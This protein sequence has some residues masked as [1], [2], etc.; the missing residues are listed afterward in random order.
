MGLI[1]EHISARAQ[2]LKPYT[3]REK[4]LLA[5]K[6][7][8]AQVRAIEAGEASINPTDVVAQGR[9]RSG[10]MTLQY[11]DDFSNIEPVIDKP[12]RAPDADIDPEIREL[13]DEETQAKFAAWT[14]DQAQKQREYEARQ[15]GYSSEEEE[16]ADL[17]AKAQEAGVYPGDGLTPSQRRERL[18]KYLEYGEGPD[19]LAGWERFISDPSNFFYSPKGTLNS[20]SDVL[21]P[22][23]PKIK[24][25]DLISQNEDE[26][27][28]MLRL[29]K[30]TGMDKDA[31][32]KIR[33]KN[34]VAHRV[35]N[36]TRMGKIQSMYFLTIAG[37]QN[38]MLGV[39]EGKAAEAE[40]GRRQA[41][42]AAI[43]NMKPVPR[44]EERTI[45][46]E[47]E[48]KVG[49]SVVQLSARPPGMS[50]RPSAVRHA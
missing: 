42:M 24:R 11:L 7:T 30:Q 19:E 49:A 5:L 41:M 13:T 36:Q 43:R 18:R 15:D 9:L 32:R 34:L 28:H 10:P 16:G 4:Q 8:P 1:A 31:I 25:P 17:Y 3:P 29:Q 46:G 40:D 50:P 26:D 23:L 33:V 38:G 44:Y 37:N 12:I 2:T 6:Y 35:V 22:E 39:G 21:A 48:G 20:Q 14:E 27:P 45:F 47:V